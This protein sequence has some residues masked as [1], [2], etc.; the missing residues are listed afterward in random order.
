MKIF[1]YLDNF[2]N[3]N[4][5]V[6]T[7]KNNKIDIINYMKI[8]DFNNQ[9]II[10]EHKNGITCILGNN[11]VINQLLDNEILITGSVNSIELE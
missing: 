2:V 8:I 3:D 11:L 6:I 9:K 4:D 7:I 10:L 1:K 5:Y